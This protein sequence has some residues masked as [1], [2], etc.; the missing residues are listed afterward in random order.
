MTPHTDGAKFSTP[1]KFGGRGKYKLKG[2]SLSRAF[3][4]VEKEALREVP[5]ALTSKA[6]ADLLRASPDS[7]ES[8]CFIECPFEF[9]CDVT[10]GS[11]L[12]ANGVIVLRGSILA[13]LECMD[14][15]FY[16]VKCKLSMLIGKYASLFLIFE[17][18]KGDCS[19]SYRKASDGLQAGMPGLKFLES[20]SSKQT[21]EHIRK[22]VLDEWNKR[23]DEGWLS[24]D[25]TPQTL[26]RLKDDVKEVV[27]DIPQLNFLSAVMVVD[28]FKSVKQ[29]KK[30]KDPAQIE[31][32]A[33]ISSLAAILIFKR[34]HS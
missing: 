21:V 33:Q 26:M 9:E 20:A 17:S 34:Y 27:S 12:N 6:V 4:E 30:Q 1:S 29:I 32:S 15:K 10:F 18:G 16:E 23:S 5:A 3:D 11:S 22:I 19:N 14:R 25:M 24:S 8:I 31:K 13:E 28:C 2:G 7:D